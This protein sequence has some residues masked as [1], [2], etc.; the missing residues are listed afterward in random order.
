MKFKINKTEYIN[1]TFRIPK[2]LSEKIARMAQASNVSS[3]EFVIQAIQFA[4]KSYE[5]ED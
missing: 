2:C 1:R 3:N 4:I 5:T